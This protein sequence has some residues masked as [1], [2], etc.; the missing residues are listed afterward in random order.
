QST[1]GG[2][3]WIDKGP[4]PTNGFGDFSDP[5]LA[6]SNVTGTIFLATV[7]APM[8]VPT[9]PPGGPGTNVFR[10]TDNCTTFI[11]PVAGSPGKIGFDQDK[12]WI[13]V[14]NFPGP[15]QGNVYLA[16]WDKPNMGGIYFFR[17]IDDGLNFGP[18]G[19][20]LIASNVD[21]E[22]DR[23]VQGAFVT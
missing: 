17:S 4:L 12:E 9:I 13:A 3:H 21:N 16:E 14:D 1:D 22:S 20:I 18:S 7:Q 23:V 2:A 6:R 10:A 8:S 19:G 11:A 15:G 5:V